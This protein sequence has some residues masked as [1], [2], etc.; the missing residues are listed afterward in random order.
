MDWS[1]EIDVVSVTPS[2][3]ASFQGSRAVLRLHDYEDGKIESIVVKPGRRVDEGTT[4]INIAV[5]DTVRALHIDGVPE[6]SKLT[7]YPLKNLEKLRVTS[8]EAFWDPTGD[9]FLETPLRELYLTHIETTLSGRAAAAFA[10][11][12]IEVFS[13]CL[14]NRSEVVYPATVTYADLWWSR[15]GPNA[16]SKRPPVKT[17]IFPFCGKEYLFA[18]D[19][20][21]W[22]LWQGVET[23]VVEMRQIANV[24]PKKPLI[25]PRTLTMYIALSTG[26]DEHVAIKALAT[27]G[28]AAKR[29]VVIVGDDCPEALTNDAEP[30]GG[31][32]RT[33]RAMHRALNVQCPGAEVEFV[34][35][36][37]DGCEY[38]KTL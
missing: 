6:S 35:P 30:C 34:R 16:F 17:V 31:I 15:V 13:L 29:I 2:E 5:P 37:L 33:E 32:F 22:A 3:L 20:D 8:S 23:A 11:S 38:F 21:C 24:V 1:K 18:D 28:A 9:F 26:V 12:K 14:R 36:D 25:R 10:K 7:I 19:D 4:R 27:I